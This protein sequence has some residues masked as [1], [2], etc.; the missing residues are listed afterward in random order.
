MRSLLNLI[1]AIT[2]VSSV[3]SQ[4]A[5]QPAVTAIRA[6]VLIDGKSNQRAP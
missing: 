4:T 1:V 2:L 5:P 3:V 6:G